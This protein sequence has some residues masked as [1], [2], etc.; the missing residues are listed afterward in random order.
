MDILAGLPRMNDVDKFA[1]YIRITLYSGLVPIT[2]LPFYY[3][4]TRYSEGEE[5]SAATW[6]VL[7]LAV[8]NAI[9]AGLVISRT[10]AVAK[11][12][13]ARVNFRQALYGHA[14]FAAASGII[15][16]ALVSI[17]AAVDRLSES[18]AVSLSQFLVFLF[19]TVSYCLAP[20]LRTSRALVLV[21]L[22]AALLATLAGSP[23]LLHFLYLAGFGVFLWAASKLSIWS[24]QVV[25]ELDKARE[26]AAQLQVKEERLRFAQQLH[27]SIDQDL[28][29]M[30]LKTQLA[31][32]FYQ[33]G[34]VQTEVHLRDLEKIVRTTREDLNQVV[35]GFRTRSPEGELRAAKLLLGSADISVTSSGDTAQI[36]PHCAETTAWFIREATTNILKHAQATTATFE[37]SPTGITVTNDGAPETIGA[38]GGTQTLQER[39]AKINGQIRLSNRDSIF[40]TQL[41]WKETL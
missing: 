9:V 11:G 38:L 8:A 32:S 24:A 21:L 7:L 35:D 2:A 14:L 26:L 25:K 1:A 33:R 39:A 4:F 23:R 18:T 12:P 41:Q 3:A 22:S 27:D 6:V 15:A 40:S 36:P 29:A 30:S 31:L 5:L 17:P 10:R 28:A 16:F 20:Q 19:L 34:D 13:V 37:V